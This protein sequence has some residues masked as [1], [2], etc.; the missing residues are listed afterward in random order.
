MERSPRD[1][2][3]SDVSPGEEYGQ[4]GICLL[5]NLCSQLRAYLVSS[6]LGDKEEIVLFVQV[7]PVQ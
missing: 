2:P 7:P 4:V 6:F 1:R 5:A 3:S